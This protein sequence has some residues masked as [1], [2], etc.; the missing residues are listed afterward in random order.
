MKQMDNLELPD[1]RLYYS[2]GEVAELLDV[3]THTLRYWEEEFEQLEPQKTP[4][5]QRRYR[6]EELEFLSRVKHLLHEEKYTTEG[7][8]QKLKLWEKQ[9]EL[10]EAPA[11]IKKIC[12]EALEQINQF[13]EREL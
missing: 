2:I 8:R 10:L 6:V 13:V 1:D 12:K 3:E 7:A 9:P 5:G 4:G 11:E